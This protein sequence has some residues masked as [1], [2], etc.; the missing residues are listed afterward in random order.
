MGIVIKSVGPRTGA[1]SGSI[2]GNVLTV[3]AIS[4]GSLDVGQNISIAGTTNAATITEKL[5]GTGGTGTYRL[6][7]SLSVG[8]ASFTA[9]RDYASISAW[10]DA[11]PVDL[12]A[13]GNAQVA[14]VYNDGEYVISSGS[15]LSIAEGSIVTSAECC[16]VVRPAADHGF[17]RHAD[18]LT[19]RMTYDPSKGVAVNVTTS[20]PVCAV[21]V[22]NFTIEGIQLRSAT[23]SGSS[24]NG[25]QG[26]NSVIRNCIFSGNLS[27]VAHTAFQLRYGARAENTLFILRGNIAANNFIGGY[28]GAKL[29]NCTV[30]RP[31]NYTVGG[32][33]IGS[34]LAGTLEVINCLTSGFSSHVGVFNGATVSGSNNMTSSASSI[35][36]GDIVSAVPTDVFVNPSNTE[37]L[38]DFRLKSNSPAINK[39]KANVLTEFDILGTYRRTPDIG[40]YEAPEP[41]DALLLIGPDGGDTQT[42]AEFTITK[43]GA[44]GSDISVTISDGSNGNFIPAATATIPAAAQSVTIRYA[45]GSAGAKQITVTNNAGLTNP[46]AKTYTVTVPLPSGQ[47]TS[48]PAPNGQQM[49]I[50]FS[51]TGS[52]TSGTARLNPDPAD[53][54]GAVE[55]DG[56]VSL[57]NGG[58]TATFENIPAGNYIPRITITNSGGTAN[59]TG[60]QPVKILGLDGGGTVSNGEDET[61]DTPTVT[62]IVI[63]PDQ[64]TS[65]NG[66]TVQLTATVF[67]QNDPPT[68]VTWTA[69]IGT[70]DS[71]GLFTPPAATGTAQTAQVRATSVFDPTRYGTAVVTVAAQAQG[72]TVSEVTIEPDSGDLTGG[73]TLQFTATVEGA[74]NPSQA[75]TWSATAG[76][77]TSG[78][79][80]TAP[81]ATLV[82]QNITVT[83]TSVLD[84]TKSA[85]AALTVAATVLPIVTGVTVSPST[86]TVAGGAT[87]QLAAAV[88]G[89]N[90][91]SQNVTWS[92][93]AGSISALGLF[94]APAATQV[95]RTIAITATSVQ[96]STKSGSASVLI[97]AIVFEDTTPPTLTGNLTAIATWTT[98]TVSWLLTAAAD[99][100][101]RVSYQYR[102]NGG[103]YQTASLLEEIAR[104]NTFRRLQHGTQY[105]IDVRV[106][107][108]SGNAS[109][110][111][112]IQIST[113]ML[114]LV[115]AAPPFRTIRVDP[116]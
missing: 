68:D 20:S 34:D 102:I 7:T 38:D 109:A 47:V 62:F 70:I 98:I 95:D 91:P 59:V 61:P 100:N 63:S 115:A 108:P 96:D 9:A 106:I 75:V 50:S 24:G 44:Y 77:I 90:S 10:R 30:V 35:I 72:P 65:T 56:V 112:T 110:P 32:R 49:V 57:T 13:D 84:P 81:A 97:P 42:L 111:L 11:L 1:G 6:S 2:S 45:P 67:G 23:S 22:D 87:L 89:L 88:F 14:E 80:F 3:T 19:S 116:D 58:G 5:T 4:S 85:A 48:Q 25:V 99:N 93:S 36:A 16:L 69:S 17:N 15:W 26:T 46:A 92:A 74:N 79:L 83:A 27:N 37:S 53:P 101:G 78:G 82:V 105:Q 8:S 114:E 12:V 104:A 66:A 39:G 73:A 31:S 41:A 60:A 76:T 28:R 21:Y 71:N 94:T 52:P 29:A 103:E 113:K 43:N 54:A 18:R 64:A 86:A 55:L 40:A 107:D 33:A 51:T